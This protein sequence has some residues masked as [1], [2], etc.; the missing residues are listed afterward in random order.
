[1]QERG[2][3]IPPAGPVSRAMTNPIRAAAHAVVVTY[4]EGFE[5]ELDGDAGCILCPWSVAWPLAHARATDT[6]ICR[7]TPDR[8]SIVW[9]RLWYSVRLSHLAELARVQ[10]G[11]LLLPGATRQAA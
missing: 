5:V 4:P 10:G 3:R 7:L 8:L 1:M 2:V 6:Y 11:P 9:P